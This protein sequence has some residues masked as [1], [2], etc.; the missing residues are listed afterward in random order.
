MNDRYSRQQLFSPIGE[1]GQKKLQFARVIIM[2]AGALG[3]ASTEMLVR[4]GV[5]SVTI[6]DRDYVE[7]SNLQR[8]QL[9]R[10]E[11]AINSLPKAQAAKTRLK[12]INRDVE[13][14]SIVTDINCSNIEELIKNQTIII[15]ATDNFETRMLM[16]DAA[17]KYH[18]P[19]IFGACVGS[20]GLTYPVIPGKTPCLNCLLAH[21]PYNGL[22]CDT[23][24]VIGPIVQWVAA[25]QVTQVL[26]YVS[27]Y[28][29]EP[30][31]RSFD[32]WKNEH[33]EINVAS[34]KNHQCESCGHQPSLP[35]L[36]Y[37]RQM[38]TAVLCGR[39]TVQIRPALP[40]ALS[41]KDLSQQLKG[42][43]QDVKT[44][45]YLLSF[46][47][48][49]HRVVLFEDGRALIHGTNEPTIAKAIYHR[50]IG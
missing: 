14:K 18:I 35:Y 15:D 16:N 2:G 19:F 38:K 49:N 11:D 3:S 17:L 23:V 8:Q 36:S 29:L 26:K 6:V 34:F 20:Y 50:I 47:Y 44:N 7:W 22:T 25:Y 28:E 48:D 24:G 4:A 9:Y 46:T 31:L 43:G 12:E 10:E 39:E 27:G 5:G 37:E 1:E 41:L 13:I 33:A 45:P 32:I 30:H 21:L 40:L 42:I